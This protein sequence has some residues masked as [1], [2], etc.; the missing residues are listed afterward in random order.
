MAVRIRAADEA[1]LEEI[2]SAPYSEDVEVA[3]RLAGDVMVLGAGGKMGPTLVWRIVRA[4][5]QAGSKARVYAVSRF[6][7]PGEREKL[8][9]RGARILSVDLLSEEGLA[10]LPECPYLIYLAG[11]KFGSTGNEE[12]TWANNVYLPGRVA[13]RFAS[14]RIVALSTGNVYPLVPIDSAGSR[15]SD[16][17]D[18]VG[19]YAQSCLGRER[20]F[21]YFSLKR[22][23]PLCLIRLNYAVEARYGV[24]VDV[25]EK[26]YEGRP[27]NVSMGYV[28]VIWQ[29]DANSICFRCLE[30]CRIPPEVL[31]LTGPEILPVRVLAE[32]FGERF[33]MEV[34]LEGR[35]AET[36]LLSDASRCR[37]RFG[38][39]RVSVDEVMDLVAHWIRKGKPRLGKPTH[40]E[41]RN[42]RF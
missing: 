15:E 29:G 40:F 18:P 23:I 1:E 2:L 42:G 16:P 9:G 41:A 8:A 34:Y 25:A 6:S 14:S 10:S 27:V 26:V 13:D 37:E 24:L 12:L 17:P 11:R 20:I 19:E 33:G 28:N 36:A 5:R 3:S 35:E 32:G 30:W 31:N 7:D 39:P 22:S 38:P 21:T 4:F